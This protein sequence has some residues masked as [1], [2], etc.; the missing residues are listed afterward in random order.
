MD[1]GLEAVAATAAAYRDAGADLVIMNL[2]HGA[3]PD[4]LGPLADALRQLA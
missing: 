4:T 2:P 1:E 3:P